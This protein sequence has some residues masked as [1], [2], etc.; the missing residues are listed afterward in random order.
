[1]SFNSSQI[2]T[3][4]TTAALLAAYPSGAV[5]PPV[6]STLGRLQ[7]GDGG[8]A[9]FYYNESDTSTADNGGTIRVDDAGRRW[10]AEESN[11]Y[12]VELFGAK[13]D[14]TTDDAT[15]FNN[16]FAAA[17]LE[18]ATVTTLGKTYKINS[19]LTFDW[20]LTGFSGAGAIL[21]FSSLSVGSAFQ[22]TTSQTDPNLQ[23]TS[24][25]RRPFSG[26]EI[27]GPASSGG[28]PCFTLVSVTVGG[29]PWFSG[30]IW[31][32]VGCS[33]FGCFYQQ[34]DGQFLQ[35]FDNVTYE[36]R[37]AGGAGAGFFLQ[38]VGSDNA[39]ENILLN[40]VVV[41]NA[42][43]VV[44]NQAP[45]PNIT[46]TCVGCSFDGLH[47]IATG[48]TLASPG[49]SPFQGSISFFGGHWEPVYYDEYLIWLGSSGFAAAFG[50]TQVLAAGMTHVPFRSD[51]TEVDGGI[52][53]ENHNFGGS[54]DW[55]NGVVCD[56]TGRF[57]IRGA[58]GPG[59]TFLTNV[60]ASSN[61]V[62]TNTFPTSGSV[63]T[64]WTGGTY[65]SSVKPAG[66]TASIRVDGSTLS[67]AFS[68]PCSPGQILN[69]QGQ[70]E[71]T[72]LGSGDALILTGAYIDAGGNQV[73]T[74]ASITFHSAIPSF[75]VES[76]PGQGIAPPGTVSAV[77]RLT[78]VPSGG[79]ASAW[80]ALPFVIVC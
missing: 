30:G 48:G 75:S 67:A 45:N 28:L 56:G 14:G 34:G 63:T 72:G 24:H 80:L 31:R 59:N 61:R 43:G 15:A 3:F 11:L 20:N 62:P 8:F 73:G 21:D 42:V 1:M 70:I 78:Y 37:T 46:I 74:A 10:Y 79:G 17:A 22:I 60:S 71:F 49:G 33:G 7:Q 77:L 53:L 57:I 44:L 58:S 55:P 26:C 50:V 25:N 2:V 47:Y 39:G 23:S 29:S 68:T 19:Q 76:Q 65:D 35:A 51:A 64:N 40:R 6:V 66:A 18:G 13:G 9:Q 38:I 4:A 12:L 27:W 5:P 69:I 16:A 41:A 32:D 52:I 36:A 54:S